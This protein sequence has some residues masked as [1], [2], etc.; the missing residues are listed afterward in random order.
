M[1]AFPAESMPLTG[2]EGDYVAPAARDTYFQNEPNL[3]APFDFDYEKIIG[4]N[5]QLRWVQFAFVPP[6]WVTSLCCYPC[7]LQQNVEWDIRSQHVALTID[8][9][10]YVKEKRKSCCGLSF[11]D[12]GRESKTVP[13]D[14]ITDCDVQEQPAGAACCCCIPNVLSKVHIDT[15]SSGVGEGGKLRHELELHGLVDAHAFKH[16]VWAM[17]RRV[18]P[19]GA[20]VP[21]TGN[22]PLAPA[23]GQMEMHTALLT[24]IRDELR[25]LNQKM[26]K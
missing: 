23:P 17:K 22:L 16:S 13:Y 11:C 1:P 19:S 12:Q 24:E 7:F 8:G 2:V 15:A 14:K 26:E 18:A 9:I 4:F 21:M 20:Q 10:R 6:F 25:L 3:I 5:T